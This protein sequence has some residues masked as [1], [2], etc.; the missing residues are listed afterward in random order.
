MW[1]KNK[2]NLDH[3]SYRSSSIINSSLLLS[4]LAK[5]ENEQHYSK[6]PGLGFNDAATARSSNTDLESLAVS[7]VY[8]NDD[9]TEQQQQQNQE[10]F[11][12]STCDGKIII[13]NDAESEELI[14]SHHGDD[15]L[16]QLNKRKGGH[17]MK[18]LMVD[19]GVGITPLA[20]RSLSSSSTCAEYTKTKSYSMEL[21]SLIDRDIKIDNNSTIIQQKNDSI[22]VSSIINSNSSENKKK[23]SPVRIGG[24]TTN[25]VN[26]R[27]VT[28]RDSCSSTSSLSSVR[29]GSVEIHEHVLDLGGS[30]PSTGPSITLGW[31]RSSHQKFDS[32]DDHHKHQQQRNSATRRRS[33]VTSSSSSIKINENSLKRPAQ[34]RVNRLLADGFTMREIRSSIVESAKDRKKRIQSLKNEPST[35]KKPTIKLSKL[36]TK[37]KKDGKRK[38]KK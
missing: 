21:L 24:G 15:F 2:S 38:T 33:S 25:I 27:D 13:S 29:F 35:L 32:I 8:D 16:K 26:K 18:L 19:D 37:S 6:Q 36:F 5:K 28:N 34:E 17:S 30:V 12:S 1:R 9:D 23:I 14:D 3:V 31:K 22:R 7:L 4:P 10:L 11:N 20:P